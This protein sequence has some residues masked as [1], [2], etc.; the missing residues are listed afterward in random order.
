MGID[1]NVLEEMVR[2]TKRTTRMVM[3]EACKKNLLLSNVRDH[4]RQRQCPVQEMEAPRCAATA[5]RGL[6]C[7][8][9]PVEEV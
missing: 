5:R 3:S 4:P 2:T 1:G 9:C 8:L 6:H 7:L